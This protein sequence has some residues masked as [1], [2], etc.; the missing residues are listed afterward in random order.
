MAHPDGPFYQVVAAGTAS[1]ASTFT[2]YPLDS[3][4]SRLQSTR[5]PI[6]LP[7]LAADVIRE[8]GI[9][10]LWRGFPLPLITIA[11]VRSISFTI[12]TGT[13]RFVNNG[14]TVN[15][16]SGFVGLDGEE[17]MTSGQSSTTS[18]IQ[19]AFQKGSGLGLFSTPSITN[20]ALTSSIA[21]AASGAVVSIGS[22]PFELVKVRRQL[23]Y[24]IARDRLERA[25]RMRLLALGKKF[26]PLK[27]AGKDLMA[28]YKPP[29]TWPAV[30]DIYREKGITGLWAGFR[31]HSVRD[32]LGTA[33][34]FAEYD[35]FRYL[36]GRD[37]LTDR[38]GPVPDW[39]K[40]WLPASLIPFSAGAVAGVTSWALIYPVD[41]RTQQRI[42][43][44]LKGRPFVTQLSRLVR[45]RDE[46]NP[47]PLLTG[48]HRLYRGLGISMM[49]SVLTHGLLWTMIDAVNRWIDTQPLERYGEQWYKE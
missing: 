33:L 28:D 17:R 43:S 22:C 9:S 16:T 41:T 29:G 3:L 6:S 10:G 8:E 47:Q 14:A 40:S 13:K 19:Q 2:G 37:P 34:Y 31:L 7:R 35:V 39:A 48:I 27:H 23:E 21:G 30:K 20:V 49:R 42:L 32:T 5:E 12:Y 1:L 15:P 36:L 38:Q 45:G 11:A 4:K 46:A 24:Q 18:Q 25:E 44:G 26:D